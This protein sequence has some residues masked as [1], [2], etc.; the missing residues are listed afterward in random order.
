[1]NKL[2][3]LLRGSLI[4]L[5]IHFAHVCVAQFSAEIGVPSMHNVINYSFSGMYTK[6]GYRQKK[7]D[8]SILG[9]TASI[10][11][12]VANRKSIGTTAEYLVM[13]DKHDWIKIK[14]GLMVM[15]TRSI[16]DNR[17]LNNNMYAFGP[18]I[19]VEIKVY[20]G[21]CLNTQSSLMYGYRDYDYS[22][23]IPRDN[24]GYHFPILLSIG[25]KQTITSK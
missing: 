7:F 11:K 4:V 9:S 13:F 3:M 1:M 24:W 5:I 17:T 23:F 16:K 6:I 12:K 19:G 25:V 20:K 18:S 21:F 10:T 14:P 8:Y 2:I 15:Y 22:Q